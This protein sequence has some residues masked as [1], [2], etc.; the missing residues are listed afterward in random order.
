MD[1]GVLSAYDEQFQLKRFLLYV[2][3]CDS[4]FE[5]LVSYPVNNSSMSIAF[6]GD[7]V[8][9][10]CVVCEYTKPKSLLVI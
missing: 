4:V 1:F 2:H 9:L 7:C 3:F 10:K 5:Q 8:T 6:T